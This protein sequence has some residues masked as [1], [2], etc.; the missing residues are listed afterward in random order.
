MPEFLGF[1]SEGRP[2]M[3]MDDGEFSTERTITVV[4]PRLNSGRPTNIPSMFNGRVVSQ[5]EAID[6]IVRNQG[7]DPETG[8]KVEGFDTLLQATGAARARSQALD[9]ELRR[10]LRG[11]GVH[12]G[13]E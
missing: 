7:V 5:G 4:D 10:I 11:A 1:T 6:I 12:P 3:R 13:S 9:S 8:R 2:L